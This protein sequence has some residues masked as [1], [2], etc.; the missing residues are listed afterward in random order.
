MLDLIGED[1]W[2]GQRIQVDFV[3]LLRESGLMR[4]RAN[5]VVDDLVGDCVGCVCEPFECG[6]VAYNVESNG[7]HLLFNRHI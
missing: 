1:S 6:C 7:L 4:R 3:E 5:V 2:F